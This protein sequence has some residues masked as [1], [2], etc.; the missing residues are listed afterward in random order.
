[1][2]LSHLFFDIIVLRQFSDSL[3]SGN[4]IRIVQIRISWFLIRF[5]GWNVAFDI[6]KSF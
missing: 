5:V 6:F 1:M 4:G 2:L 3:N